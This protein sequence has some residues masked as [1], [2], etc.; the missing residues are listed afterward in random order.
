MIAR[1]AS[2]QVIL[3]DLSLILFL[4]VLAG[5][6][7]NAAKDSIRKA[8]LAD[9]AHGAA[10]DEAGLAIFRPSAESGSLKDWLEQQAPDDR[11]QLTV[12]A[13]FAPGEEQQAWQMARVFA[14]A[15]SGAGHG[16]RIVLS[17]GE[18]SEAWLVLGYDRELPPD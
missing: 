12:H 7:Q 15:A 16:A 5:L 6:S 13:R 8:E 10:I 2:W 17:E 14:R 4:T 9:H 3:A 18:K 11:T 1:Q